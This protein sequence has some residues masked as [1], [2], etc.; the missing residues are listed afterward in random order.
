MTGR[1][2]GLVLALGTLLLVPVPPAHAGCSWESH[3][4]SVQGALQTVTEYVCT[5]DGSVVP[6]GQNDG[7][8]H[9]TDMNLDTV[10]TRTAMSLGLD[11]YE[12]CLIPADGSPPEV[13]PVLVGALLK[14]LPLPASVLNVQP[15]NGRTLV[16]FDSNF[17]TET[18]PFDRTMVLLGQRVELHIVP[19]RFGWNFG[20]GH[21]LST[22]KPGAPYPD[23]DVTHRYLRKGSVTPS[24]DTTYTATF[25]VNGGAW[26]D[27]P[28][29]VT[30]PGAP[31]PLEVLTA[32]PTLVGY[33]S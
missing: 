17:F 12:V 3:V 10:C 30:I 28:G 19:S 9:P 13:T 33:D 1:L 16:N 21:T 4:E 15:V 26:R 23:L 6:A 11:P 18:R 14:R 27:V 24:V 29:A 31:V 8:L 5:G 2:V 25:R 20:D 32:T 22:D 7:P